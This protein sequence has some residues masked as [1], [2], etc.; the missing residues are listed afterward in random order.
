MR[1]RDEGPSR[2]L[3]SAYRQE[4]GKEQAGGPSGQWT[5]W[6]VQYRWKERAEAYD[7]HLEQQARAA[8][9]AEHLRDLDAYRDRQ[10]WLAIANLESAI[11]MLNMGN[12]RLADLEQSDY[13]L[14]PETLPMWFRAMV[15][16]A[17]AAT[18]AEAQALAVG[19]LLGLLELNS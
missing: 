7:A 19:E 13:L 8:R 5:G 14:R 6:Y 17:E 12:K 10:K 9:E 1:Y 18:N 3:A 11:R 2:S 15:T 4:T 16:I